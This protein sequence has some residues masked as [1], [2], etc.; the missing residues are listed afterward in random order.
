MPFVGHPDFS[1]TKIWKLLHS[2]NVFFIFWSWTYSH[3]KWEVLWAIEHWIFIVAQHKVTGHRCFCNCDVLRDIHCSMV[4]K[5]TLYLCG[6][7]VTGLWYK[8]CKVKSIAL[9]SQKEKKISKPVFISLGRFFFL[10]RPNLGG[11]RFFLSFFFA[12]NIKFKFLLHRTFFYWMYFSHKVCYSYW[13]AILTK[14]LW[15]CSSPT[16]CGLVRDI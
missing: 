8:T 13:I 7:V 14:W 4:L 11:K 9:T 16:Y 2:E 3:K 6:I 5:P 1:V 15:S 12:K 10:Y